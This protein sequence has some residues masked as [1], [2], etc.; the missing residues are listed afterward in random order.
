MAVR[1]VVSGETAY[2]MVDTPA[3]FERKRLGFRA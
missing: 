1:P 3:N 2:R